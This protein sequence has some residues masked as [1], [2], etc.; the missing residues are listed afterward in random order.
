MK[1]IRLNTEMPRP[2]VLA[3]QAGREN[4]IGF[5]EMLMMGIPGCMLADSCVSLP[6][7]AK[8]TTRQTVG[9]LFIHNFNRRVQGTGYI[10]SS[11]ETRSIRN[12]EFSKVKRSFFSMPFILIILQYIEYSTCLEN[13]FDQI[14][15][16]SIVLVVGRL[17]RV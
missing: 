9:V 2:Q 6:R 7:R 3:H 5:G 12:N 10:N 8:E 4:A 15:T 11:S 13:H 1:C 17:I 14:E 16:G